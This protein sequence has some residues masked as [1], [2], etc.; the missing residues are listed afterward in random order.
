MTA[1]DKHHAKIRN[2]QDAIDARLARA[3]R[4]FI[5][6]IQ[7]Q[8][9]AAPRE[10]LAAVMRSFPR[11][12]AQIMAQAMSDLLGRAVGTEAVGRLRVGV[13]GVTLSGALWADVEATGKVVANIIQRHA[14]GW[15]DARALALE[16]FEGYGF[17]PREALRLAPQNHAL[18]KYLRTELLTDPGIRGELARFFARGRASARKTAPLRQSYLDALDA[19]EA[20]RGQAVLARKLEIAGFEKLRY[21]A[22]RIARTELARAHECARALELQARDD[23]QFVQVRMSRAHPAPDICDY[24]A[25]IDRYGLGKGVYPKH[26]APVP[27][28]HPHCLCV[29]APRIDFDE[30]QKWRERPDAGRDWLARQ[31][32]HHAARIAGSRDKRDAILQGRAELLDLYNR[33]QHERYRI[34][35]LADI[36]PEDLAVYGDQTKNEAWRPQECKAHSDA[37]AAA[38][39]QGAPAAVLHAEDAPKGDYKDVVDF[40]ASMFASQGGIAHQG[41]IGDV[42]MVRRSAKNTMAHGD[43][44]EKRAA[45]SALQSVVENGAVVLHAS[46]KTAESYY[47]SAPVLIHGLKSGRNP[48]HIVTAVLREDMNGVRL[49][50]HSV[51]EKNS[52]LAHPGADG[53]P[54]ERPGRLR[55]PRGNVILPE[56][57]HDG[58]A[59]TETVA[60]RLRRLLTMNAK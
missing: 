10:A 59:D 5:A 53:K 42:K 57:V 35:T 9:G 27:P 1:A 25:S 51:K 34:R 4:Q 16:M 52:L 13:A 3:W 6:Q 26:L 43:S 31:D 39:M 19:I 45:L 14:R 12:Q 60:E 2:A 37:D 38:I 24:H 50:L 47:V 54:S 36:R 17:R 29:L 49:Y 46:H 7:A 58:K 30:D 15:A 22:Q 8:A 55:E 18:P 32:P 44:I 28:Y 21:N 23:V 11:A 33:A 56:G 48:E 20:G 41:K 40:A